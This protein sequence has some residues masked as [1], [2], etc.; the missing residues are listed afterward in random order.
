MKRFFAV[1]GVALF[2][3][4]PAVRAQD[5]W[6]PDP[7]FRSLFNGKDLTG[8]VYTGSKDKLDGATETSDK[9]FFVKDGIIVADVGK[10]IK[11]LYT[12]EEFDQEFVLKLEFRAS[13]K[14][15]SGVYVRGP[16]LQVRDYIRRGEQKQLKKFKDDDW[17]ALE[18]SV[19]NKV[20]TY[21][22][23][24]LA[25]TDQLSVNVKDGVLTATL[26]GKPVPAANI[27]IS[28]GPVAHCLCNGEFIEDMKV[29]AKG[30]I[31]L[32]AETGKFEFRRVQIKTEA[33]AKAA[34]ASPLPTGS[35]AVSLQD[36]AGTKGKRL[37]LIT[38]SKGF[39]HPV[40]ARQYTIVAKD[41]SLDDFPK[42]DGLEVTLNKDKK[43]AVKYQG[44]LE[45]PLEIKKG[46]KVLA[47]AR[48]C[49]VET[50]FMALGEKHGFSVVCSQNSRAEITGDLLKDY[51]AVFFYTTG[52]LPL[53]DAQKSD[54]L[55]FVKNGK[56]FG[57]SHCATD[58]FYKWKEYEGLIGAWF[59]SHP[60]TQKVRVIVEDQKHPATKHLGDSFF[61]DDEIYQYRAPYSREKGHVLMKL[62]MDSVKG[63]GKRTDSDNALAWVHSYGKGRVFYTALGHRPEVWNDPRFQDHIVGGL[64][65]MFG[66]EK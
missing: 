58:T 31:G 34:S 20:I 42:M 27:N 21:N 44:R 36:K 2:V 60:W 49:L 46:D 5:D 66:L 55:G 3:A 53:S 52:E 37:L 61:I 26:N 40:S 6:K 12:T 13:L 47:I 48:P 4:L 19:R 33:K 7:G 45:K 16:Q 38:E 25:A 30:G 63:L 56:G 35:T 22:N 62:D 51:D 41:A 32:Q 1:L 39:P 11:D 18:I 24:P 57:G 15:D 64:R 29:P 14:A 50:T 17:N 28:S 43:V 23:K 8:W 9:R 65:D 59:T 54:L 10:G